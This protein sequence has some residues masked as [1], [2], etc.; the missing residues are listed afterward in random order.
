MM[1]LL[2][3]QTNDYDEKKDFYIIGM[4]SSVCEIEEEL[5]VD[6]EIEREKR[7]ATKLYRD[8]E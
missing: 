4:K 3:S 6:D 5:D 2:T 8:K 7:M 1:I